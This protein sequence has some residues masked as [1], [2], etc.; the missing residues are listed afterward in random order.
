MRKFP[1]TARPPLLLFC[2]RN[3]IKNYIGESMSRETIRL[4]YRTSRAWPDPHSPLEVLVCVVTSRRVLLRRA[5]CTPP[6]NIV[7]CSKIGAGGDA[8]VSCMVFIALR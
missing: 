7:K 6:V 3:K 5:I 4:I 2:F 8:Y 1:F